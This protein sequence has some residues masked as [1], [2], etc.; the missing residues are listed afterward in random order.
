MRSLEYSDLIHL[1]EQAT[2]EYYKLQ[3]GEISNE[4]D[5]AMDN[6]RKAVS[7]SNKDS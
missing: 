2:A 7:P 1:C 4:L 3:H 5:C 6:L